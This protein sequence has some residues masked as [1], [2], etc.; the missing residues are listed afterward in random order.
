MH[1]IINF[2]HSN[3]TAHQN[4]HSLIHVGN[5]NAV[6]HK[7]RRITNLDGHLADSAA[8]IHHGGDHICRS[9]IIINHFNQFHHMRRVK[10][11]QTDKTGLILQIVCHIG[12]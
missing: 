12:Y 6:N 1:D 2:P 8:K 5:Q 11:M 3:L 7:S 10:K 9:I 4:Q